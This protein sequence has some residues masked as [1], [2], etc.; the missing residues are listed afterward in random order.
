MPTKQFFNLTEEKRNIL[1]QATIDELNRVSISDFSINQVVKKAGIARGS[2]YIY[3]ENVQDIIEY[4]M[5][6]YKNKLYE[7]MTLLL[8]KN[9]GDIFETYIEIFNW[10]IDFISSEENINM[11]QNIMKYLVNNIDNSNIK[12]CREDEKDYIKQIVEDIDK[13]LL[14]IF[15]EK[16]IYLVL[17]IL[18]SISKNSIEEI[19][20]LKE[21]KNKIVKRY[22][23]KIELVKKGLKLR[24]GDNE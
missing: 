23:N 13:K 15:E 3:F 9:N 10:I 11:K 22:I 5:K 2:F 20:I 21:D 4:V 8:K 14:N 12:K 19:V 17:D 18:N 7:N 16:E 24:G 6:E 1:L